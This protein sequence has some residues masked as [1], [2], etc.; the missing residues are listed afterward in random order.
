M[1]RGTLLVMAGFGMIL[2]GFLLVFIG[3][4][5]SSLG[6]GEV[7]GG[8]VIMIGPI[9]IIFGRGRGAS[10]AAVLAIILMALWI[11]GFLLTRRG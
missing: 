10:V 5:I 3:T 4:V 6:D 11:I 1:D 9:P 7:E 2:L 8:G